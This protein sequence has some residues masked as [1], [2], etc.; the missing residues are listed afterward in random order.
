M[1]IDMLSSFFIAVVAF[2]SIPLA[3]SQCLPHRYIESLFFLALD[4][5]LVG[6]TLTYSISLNGAFQGCIRN[7]AQ[8]ESFV[9]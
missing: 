2:A 4:A 8:V 1:R 3:S 7:G 9:S 6:L 5:G